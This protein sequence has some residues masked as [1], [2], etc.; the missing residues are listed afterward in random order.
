MQ[1]KDYHIHT[2]YSDG[3]NTPEEMI[4]SAIN[5]GLVELGFSD[6]S[7]TFFDESYCI[8]KDKINS[9]KDE[10]TKLKSKYKDKISIKLGIEQ[11]IFSTESVKDYDY[12]IGS[13]HYI[14]VND[15]Y[16][17]PVDHSLDTLK[18]NTEKWLGGDYYLLAEIYYK[19]LCELIEKTQCNIVGHIDLI[20][21]YIENEKIFDIN[22][23]RYVKAWMAACDKLL[24][25]DVVFEINSGAISR[26]Y[27]TSP[28]PMSDMYEYLKSKGAKFIYGSDSHNKDTI[29]F[30]N[31]INMTI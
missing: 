1:L 26:G 17:F 16:Y 8:K 27:R 28:Y 3:Q 23:P 13:V 30:F 9:Y 24:K 4:E 29:C 2:I 6:H 10:I 31:N 20:T 25:H 5:K 14:K 21:K 18:E 7:Y 22:N 15:N 11:D 19:Q 12:V